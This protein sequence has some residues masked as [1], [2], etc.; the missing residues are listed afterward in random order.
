MNG[1]FAAMV[2]V[3]MGGGPGAAAPAGG[4]IIDIVAVV[5]RSVAFSVD[6]VM[7]KTLS[8]FPMRESS[9]CKL[10]CLHVANPPEWKA[11]EPFK[12]SMRHNNRE[13]LSRKLSHRQPLSSVR[14]TISRLRPRI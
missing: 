6:E 8:L 7:G 10:A 14:P 3:V 13:T 4:K 2:E 1:A 12:R 11:N 5:G 9:P